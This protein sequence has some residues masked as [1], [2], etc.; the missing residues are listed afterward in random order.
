MTSRGRKAPDAFAQAAQ[1]A[2]RVA[3]FLVPINCGSC[4]VAKR[5]PDGRLLYV[6]FG[7]LRG[8]RMICPPCLEGEKTMAALGEVVDSDWDDEVPF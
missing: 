6:D 3:T 1:N 7:W 2:P 5:A 8:K 4:G